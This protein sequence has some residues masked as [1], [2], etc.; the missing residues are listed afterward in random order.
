MLDRLAEVIR[1]RDA[2]SVSAAAAAAPPTGGTG[3]PS[4]FPP[5]RTRTRTRSGVGVG[6]G[7][8]VGTGAFGGD[9]DAEHS[10][11]E[12][13]L[14]TSRRNGM[15]LSW[16]R[17]SS[18]TSRGSS[19]FESAPSVRGGTGGGGG[20][21]G[22]QDGEVAVSDGGEISGRRRGDFGGIAGFGKGGVIPEDGVVRGEDG[23]AARKNAAAAGGVRDDGMRGEI[24]IGM[25]GSNGGGVLGG[26]VIGGA[27][28]ARRGLGR[29][30]AGS[31]MSSFFDTYS[32][33]HSSRRR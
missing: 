21:G 4:S 14:T 23:I 24:K 30:S 1:A 12:T 15:G 7:V 29:N 13:L 25:R 19:W 8:G 32:R 10:A 3:R 28:L 26:G 17:G 33:G 5:S 6:V 16:W 2:T 27:G 18:L 31:K 20:G 22:S 9:E 11:S